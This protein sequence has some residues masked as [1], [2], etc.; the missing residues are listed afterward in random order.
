M[1]YALAMAVIFGMLLNFD[2]RAV[3]NQKNLMGQ[4]KISLSAQLMQQGDA[5]AAA[6]LEEKSRSD[7][8]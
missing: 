8:I 3:A 6:T 1:L 7:P 4:K 2:L 5:G